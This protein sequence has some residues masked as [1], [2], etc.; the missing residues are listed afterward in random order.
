MHGKDA[1]VD[2][3]AIR[4]RGIYRNRF[5]DTS[6]P[7]RTPGFGD[8]NWRDVFSIL[9]ENGYEGDVCIEGYHDPIYSGEWEMTGQMHALKYLK[10]CRGGDFILIPGMLRLISD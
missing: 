5:F 10:F 4:R 2:W 6:V 8:T 3:E 9:H 1:S 7:E